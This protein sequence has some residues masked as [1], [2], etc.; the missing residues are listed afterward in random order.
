MSKLE[1]HLKLLKKICCKKLL[2]DSSVYCV[3]KNFLS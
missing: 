3:I 1:I 2:I